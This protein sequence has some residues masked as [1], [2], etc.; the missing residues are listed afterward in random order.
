MS[1]ARRAGPRQF[2]GLES[3]NPLAKAP[4]PDGATF[5]DLLIFEERLKQN[6][7]RLLR[8]KRKYQTTLAL[9]CSA[10]L[11]LSYHVLLV[12][13]SYVPLHYAQLALL[14]VCCTTLFLFFASGM[15]AERIVAANRFVPQA[16]RAL[17]PFNMYL[18][19][20]PPQKAPL[21]KR[22]LMPW[23]LRD[24]ATAAAATT[25]TTSGGVPVK[26]TSNPPTAPSPVGDA[27]L[28][29][30]SMANPTIRRVQ[31]PPIP[32]SG[33]PRG[34]IIFSTRVAPTFREGYH[35]YR[36]A[37]ERRRREKL[38]AVARETSWHWWPAALGPGSR[39][40]RWGERLIW[41]RAPLVPHTAHMADQEKGGMLG[42]SRGDEHSHGNSTR[43][44][45]SAT[46]GSGRNVASMNRHR[47]DSAASSA[48]ASSTG[49]GTSARGTRR[50]GAATGTSSPRTRTRA[51][52]DEDRQHGGSGGG[53]SSHSRRSSVSLSPTGE[54]TGDAR[55]STGTSR[56]RSGGSATGAKRA[57][58]GVAG[59]RA[60]GIS[61]RSPPTDGSIPEG[62]QSQ[63]DGPE[64]GDQGAIITGEAAGQLR[65]ASEPAPL[66]LQDGGG[67][68]SSSQA[69]TGART[70]SSHPAPSS[71]SEERRER[72]EVEAD[73][74]I[75]NTVSGGGSSSSSSSSSSHSTHSS[76][77]GWIEVVRRSREPSAATTPS[78][79]GPS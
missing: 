59:K 16:N 8:R 70:D 28:A 18:N 13:K 43:R 54:E 75:S 61:S 15:Y 46:T 66:L 6:A 12:P 42:S 71:L 11:F 7:A 35:R 2:P 21:W 20:R 74:T 40:S 65:P 72:A 68:T 55:K 48:S 10:I 37:F 33:N 22:V 1:G 14:V 76:D 69:E 9:L 36:N 53:G 49:S 77:G 3:P 44:G 34:E 64:S 23:A 60:S 17:R 24:G 39:V 19:I 62:S 29:A 30:A 51:L 67:L 50:S 45:S 41:W 63:T 73:V 79:H 56:G 38:E 4:A 52:A 31:I 26:R 32:P 25:T 58:S 78:S 47:S 5:R 57:G 27:H